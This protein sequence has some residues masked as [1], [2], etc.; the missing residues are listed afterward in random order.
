[1]I[2]RMAAALAVLLVIAGCG[3][4]SDD[5][6][7]GDLCMNRALTAVLTVDV[8]DPRSIWATN[9]ATGNTL[10]LRLP[11]GY[12]VTADDEI[13]NADGRVIGETGDVIVGGCADL[14]QDALLITETNIRHEP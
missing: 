4:A 14:L 10:S 3:S 2:R 13:V 7:S 8:Q 6:L 9:A 1:M 12:G 5:G 11:D